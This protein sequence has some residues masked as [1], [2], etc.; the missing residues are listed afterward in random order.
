MYQFCLEIKKNGEIPLQPPPPRRSLIVAA[1]QNQEIFWKKIKFQN[2]GHNI[3]LE[4]SIYIPDLR[5]GHDR[6]FPRRGRAVNYLF[7]IRCQLII[8][9]Y[10]CCSYS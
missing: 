6:C 8:R 7:V 2:G 1:V 4:T 5:Q 3:K 9:Q 10:A